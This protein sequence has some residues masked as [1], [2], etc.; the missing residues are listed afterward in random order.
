MLTTKLVVNKSIKITMER[1]DSG[2]EGVTPE[3]KLQS[4]KDEY[5]KLDGHPTAEAR[6]GQQSSRRSGGETGEES[7]RINC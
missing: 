7:R 6:R 3:Q 1:T 2:N 5:D 4:F